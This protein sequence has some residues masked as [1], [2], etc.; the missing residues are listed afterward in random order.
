MPV[1]NGRNLQHLKF[2]NVLHMPEFKNNLLS[3]LF[4]TCHCKS[5]V[6]ITDKAIHFVQSGQKHFSAVDSDTAFLSGTTQYA[7]Q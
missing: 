1:V 5:T 3:V 7:L 2:T 6:H 4:L